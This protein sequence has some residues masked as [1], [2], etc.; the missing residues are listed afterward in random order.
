VQGA[1]RPPG[2]STAVSGGRNPIQVGLGMNIG[3]ID[4]L[5]TQGNLE[6]TGDETDLGI[7][8]N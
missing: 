5:F 8:G 4:M 3:S 1:S 7:Q 2:G 6:P